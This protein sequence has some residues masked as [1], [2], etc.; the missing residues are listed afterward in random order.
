MLSEASEKNIASKDIK[1]DE[2]LETL[3][4]KYD[5]LGAR[6]KHIDFS[7]NDVY[8][9]CTRFRRHRVRCFDGTGGVSWSDGSLRES[10]SLRLFG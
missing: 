3:L 10:S 8:L 5:S 7:L 4:G 6:I 2:I 9:A 1:L